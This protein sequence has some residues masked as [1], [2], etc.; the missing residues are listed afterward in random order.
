MAQS[1]RLTYVGPMRRAGAMV[2]VLIAV[3]SL[4]GCV[5]IDSDVA[6]QPDALGDVVITTTIC[7]TALNDPT[8]PS[9]STTSNQPGGN[10]GQT[11]AQLLVAYHVPAA[12]AVQGSVKVTRG[13]S[14]TTLTRNSGFE[15]ILEAAGPT[16]NMKWVGY[17]SDV[18]PAN[19]QMPGVTATISATFRLPR[20]DGGEPTTAPFLYR[21]VV[22]ARTVNNSGAGSRPVACPSPVTGTSTEDYN[23]TPGT[24]NDDES[25][26]CVDAPAGNDTF[27]SS[28]SY[29]VG[30][31]GIPGGGAVTATQGTAV[32]VPFV[33]KAA[34]SGLP[35][36]TLTAGTTA[37][38]AQATPSQPQLQPTAGS[39]SVPVSVVVPSNTPVG[40]Y[41]VKLQATAGSQLREGKFTLNVVAPD[42]VPSSG[43]PQTP[44][45]NPPQTPPADTTAPVVGLKA[46][47]G[48]KL[49]TVLKKGLKLA[50]T[51]N[52][53]CT[54]TIKVLAGKTTVAS[55]KGSVAK[56]TKA[57]QK[58]YKKAKKLT[59][60]ATVS[61][62]DAAGNK[63]VK[64]LTVKLKR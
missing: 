1:L 10:S 6:S 30:D 52:E 44:P 21:T 36:M 3:L 40:T 60:I 43:Q 41:D 33:V 11:P 37:P 64:S 49:A 53:T 4:S 35:I 8:C 23:N 32:S 17:V 12:A 51:C 18:L 9:S 24:T 45:S 39:Q 38:A 54:D 25:T 55:G 27:K 15:A 20:P 31:V 7:P 63:T 56:F 59:L 48:Q 28:A 46:V 42:A 16:V 47:K 22:G 19:Q 34:G 2:A 62:S 29:T 14:T 26:V 58:K 61:A 5:R 50:V 57:A 13:A